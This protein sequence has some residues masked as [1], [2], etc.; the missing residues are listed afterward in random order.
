[1]KIIGKLFWIAGWL[2]L[3]LWAGMS[4]ISYQM[5]EGKF[6]QLR[7]ANMTNSDLADISITLG[8]Q[9]MQMNKIA[10]GD[11]F[12]FQQPSG[13]EGGIG[14]TAILNGAT[15]EC[16]GGYITSGFSSSTLFQVKENGTI[17]ASF[18]NGLVTAPAPSLCTSN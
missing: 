16:G 17:F 5:D 4:W 1:M 14:F 2:F 18:S 9:E 13:P 11:V 8:R 3:V 12:T 7:I 15:I 6:N 10:P